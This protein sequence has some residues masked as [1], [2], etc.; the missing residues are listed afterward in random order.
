MEKYFKK[1]LK[2]S[3][4]KF[5]SNFVLIL[6]Q[7]QKL[8]MTEADFPF[9]PVETR[10]EV[11]D[12]FDE[13]DPGCFDDWSKRYPE[14]KETVQKAFKRGLGLYRMRISS[15]KGMQLKYLADNEM[16]APLCKGHDGARKSAKEM[17]RALVVDEWDRPCWQLRTFI[18]RIAKEYIVKISKTKKN[19]LK[20]SK[21]GFKMAK[22]GCAAVGF[23]HFSTY[24][25]KFQLRIRRL[26]KEGEK[27]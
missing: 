4:F 7:N 25:R 12:A 9:C 26:E 3:G 17:F 22:E 1:C 15:T 18:D 10:Q 24:R 6:I 8:K 2:M 13:L 27:S 11:L 19:S 23:K 21:Q 5:V 14:T 20:F 16:W